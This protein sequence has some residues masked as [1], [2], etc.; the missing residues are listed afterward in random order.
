M[1]LK[2]GN[3]TLYKRGNN[4]ERKIRAVYIICQLTFKQLAPK[5]FKSNLILYVYVLH[6]ISYIYNKMNH[7]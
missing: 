3:K 4:E 5:H 2:V 7:I 1:A 6:V